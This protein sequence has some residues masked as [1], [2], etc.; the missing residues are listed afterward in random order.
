MPSCLPASS[1][2][3]TNRPFIR[4]R[5]GLVLVTPLT[6]RLATQYI[7]EAL[8]A[9]ASAVGRFV[10]T[11]P[12]GNLSSAGPAAG[13]ASTAGGAGAGRAGAAAAASAFAAGKASRETWLFAF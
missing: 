12:P 3:R 1:P 8:A 4:K 5:A 7:K 10:T 9:G 11:T 6:V 2:S 13:A